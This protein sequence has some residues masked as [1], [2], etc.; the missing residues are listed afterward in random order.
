MVLADWGS[1]RI[2]I[3]LSDVA[4]VWVYGGWSESEKELFWDTYALNGADRGALT[5]GLAELMTRVLRYE[6][7]VQSLLMLNLGDLDSIGRQFLEKA[8]AAL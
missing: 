7:C 8:I 3:P 5:R 1:A 6:I 4:S 2:G